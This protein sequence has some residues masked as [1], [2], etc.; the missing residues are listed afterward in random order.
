MIIEGEH[1]SAYIRS[2]MRSIIVF[3]TLLIASISFGQ[4]P[5][6]QIPDCNGDCQPAIWVGDG[7]C[8]D[9]WASPADFLCAAFN[10]DDGDCTGPGC[11][12]DSFCTSSCYDNGICDPYFEACGCSDCVAIPQCN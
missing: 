2:A 3:P 7:V 9:G 12:E 8:D 11:A 4:C 10:W 5:F 1:L 6:G